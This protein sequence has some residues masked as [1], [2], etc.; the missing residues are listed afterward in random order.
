MAKSYLTE[1]QA[2]GIISGGSNEAGT[3]SRTEVTVYWSGPRNASVFIADGE[4]YGFLASTRE[5]SLARQFS[6]V[7]AAVKAAVRLLGRA[8]P[9]KRNPG[10]VFTV[11]V[12]TTLDSVLKGL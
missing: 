6:T 5:P 2:V 7:D 8:L 3:H 9:G 11:A 10:E 4:F 12:V 1:A